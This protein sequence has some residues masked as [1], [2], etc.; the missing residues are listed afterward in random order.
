MKCGECRLG[1]RIGELSVQCNLDPRH[2]PFAF[3]ECR[4]SLRE[5]VEIRNRYR[6][7]AQLLDELVALREAVE[8]GKP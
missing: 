4:F 8:E 3:S 1:K 6:R 2:Y 5:L 7:L